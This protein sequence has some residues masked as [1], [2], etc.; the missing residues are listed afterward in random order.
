MAVEINSKYTFICML[1]LI[2]YF[3][4][5]DKFI[6]WFIFVIIGSSSMCTRW[7]ETEIHTYFDRYKMTEYLIL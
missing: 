4:Q 2:F 3:R 5:I 1:K 6:G 7:S